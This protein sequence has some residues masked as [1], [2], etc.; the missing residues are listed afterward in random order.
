MGLREIRERIRR[1]VDGK[2]SE[3]PLA[4]VTASVKQRRE[5]EEFIAQ[6]SKQ[7]DSVMQKEMFRTPKGAVNIPPKFLVFLSSDLDKQWK[8]STKRQALKQALTEIT[9]E[10]AQELRGDTQPSGSPVVDL[11]VDGT[12]KAQEFRVQAMWDEEGESTIFIP[13]ESEETVLDPLLGREELYSLEV[14]QG[15]VRQENVPVT[16]EL[17]TIGRGSREK[18]VDV[19]IKGDPNISRIHA[20]LRRGGKGQFGLTVKGLNPI[21][22]DGRRLEKDDEARVAPGQ[23]IKISSYTLS[24]KTKAGSKSGRASKKAAKKGSKK[25]G[26]AKGRR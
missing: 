22:L 3:D 14:W 26:T 11:R 6:V 9:V 8:A 24:I 12:L 16:K 2:E 15:G 10:R 5:A 20:E 19:P 4:D 25:R 23:K 21:F 17:V 1:W 13:E 7:I 18:P